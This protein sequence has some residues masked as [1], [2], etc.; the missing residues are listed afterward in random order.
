MMSKCALPD[1][2]HAFNPASTRWHTRDAGCEIRAGPSSGRTMAYKFFVKYS[3]QNG[4]LWRKLMYGLNL[5]SDMFVSRNS[6]QYPLF[7][8]VST[9]FAYVILFSPPLISEKVRAFS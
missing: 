3:K 2:S 9:N 8:I 5:L 4:N 6:I 7:R 1:H